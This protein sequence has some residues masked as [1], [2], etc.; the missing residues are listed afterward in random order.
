MARLDRFSLRMA[1]VSSRRYACFD[2]R[3]DLRF[4][5]RHTRAMVLTLTR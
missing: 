1:M 4:V 2:L 5:M 3:F